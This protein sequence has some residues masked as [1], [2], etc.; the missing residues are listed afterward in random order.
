MAAPRKLLVIYF[1][2]WE[3]TFT[4]EWLTFF[5]H[6][7]LHGGWETC[8]LDQLS[9]TILT[10]KDI[11]V[12]VETAKPDVVRYVQANPGPKYIYWCDD[13]HHDQR[14]YGTQ[15]F[16]LD[17]P[18]I[19]AF[20][21]TV[22]TY[23][24]CPHYAQKLYQVPLNPEPIPQ[25]L[26]SGA[27][28][29]SNKYYGFRNWVVHKSKTDKRI[30]VLPHHQK[31]GRE[32]ALHINQYLAA[33]TSSLNNTFHYVFAKVFEITCTGALL[34]IEDVLEPELKKLG[35]VDNVNCMLV[36]KTN[37]NNKLNYILDLANRRHVDDMRSAG[38]RL[39][40]TRH[41]LPNRTDQ[42]EKLVAKITQNYD[43]IDTRASLKY[44]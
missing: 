2:M 15:L 22:N 4:H 21:D 40:Q 19:S 7:E 32:Y 3:E 23:F 34:V 36:N 41:M 30:S 28:F 18:V 1:P 12:F 27:T 24:S 14:V 5:K 26:M 20:G 11:I 17:I 42:F 35:F 31:Y 10:P 37:F 13:V 8:M 43:Q 9:Q 38:Q 25:L 16:Q 44:Q 29:T 33:V 39:T 6:L